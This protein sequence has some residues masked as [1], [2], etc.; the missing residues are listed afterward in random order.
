[1]SKPIH[2]R[3][4]RLA[5]GILASISLTAAAQP[6][7]SN[8]QGHAN[9]HNRTIEF[10][11][12]NGRVQPTSEFAAKV[13]VLGASIGSGGSSQ[14]PVATW[15]DIGD[16]RFYPF[17]RANPQQGNVNDDA[18][19][20]HVVID[21]M[22]D[23]ED[24]HVSA[25]SWRPYYGRWRSLGV[26][27][28]DSNTPMVKV[29]RDGDPVPAIRAWDN[30]ANVEIF[31]QQYIDGDTQT[32]DIDANQVIYLFELF[33]TSPTSTYADYQDLVVL[34]TLGHSPAELEAAD[35]VVTTTV[36]PLFD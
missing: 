3:P 28:T 2:A 15:I 21:Q 32:V 10:Q 26:R 31:I 35:H 4:T 18:G 24:I 17:G 19:V 30:Q 9:G 20:R 12:D 13:S 36:L 1:M 11:I 33:A 14:W 8:G 16:E 5:A 34:V 6:A 22:F 23:E 27:S 7:Q 29:L 25:V